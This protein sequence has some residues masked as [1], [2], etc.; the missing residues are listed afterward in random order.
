MA[1]YTYQQKMEFLSKLYCPARRAS[2]KTGLSW[3]TIMAQAMLETGSGEKILSGTNNVFN[4]KANKSWAG[5]K[6]QHLVPEYLPVKGKKVKV[7]VNDWFRNYNSFED[8]LIDRVQF[9]LNDKNYKIIKNPNILGNF[10]KEAQALQDCGYATDS[11][12]KTGEKIYAKKLKEMFYCPLMKKAIAL[13]ESQG[14]CTI[15]NAVFLDDD[16]SKE[17]NKKVEIV[18]DGNIAVTKVTDSNAIIEGIVV[19]PNGTISFKKD[20][21][22]VP[23]KIPLAKAPLNIKVMKAAT[24]INDKLDQHTG[25]PSIRS[26]PTVQHSTQTSSQEQKNDKGLTSFKVKFTEGDTN[27]SV[28]NFSYGIF[29]KNRM[30]EH[31]VDSNGEEQI[32]AEAGAKIEI[33]VKDFSGSLNQ[34]IEEFNVVENISKTIKIPIREIKVL[35]LNHS[36]TRVME[37]Y[38]RFLS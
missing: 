31:I 25:S 38:N 4:I 11:D 35:I 6:S 21:I 2:F 12:E 13:A 23:A 9:I 8:S 32:R 1:V 34:K 10:E 20:N 24:P 26:E 30:K 15:V 36:S 5:P 7:M 3:K 22:I 37:N 33:Y 28:G 18:V 14:Y 29:Y 27:K 19:N 17:V 16:N